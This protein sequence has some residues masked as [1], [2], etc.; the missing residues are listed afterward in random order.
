MI[1]IY[2]IITFLILASCNSGGDGDS[3]NSNISCRDTSLEFVD[4]GVDFATWNQVADSIAGDFK[5]SLMG[6]PPTP[7]L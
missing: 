5:F 6:S 3:N 4:L 7:I 1:R 2:L